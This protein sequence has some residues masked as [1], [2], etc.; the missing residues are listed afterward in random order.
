MSDK[1][2]ALNSFW[3]GFGLPAYDEHTVPDGA[4]TPYITYEASTAD[5]DEKVALTASIWYKSNSW[6]EVSQKSEEIS[7]RIGGG[8]GQP[9]DNGR[10]WIT[11]ESPFAQ[12]MEEPDDR[13][14]RRI[15]LQIA[16]EFH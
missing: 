11:K 14:I 4:V 7:Q 13:L 8:I 9:Y 16:A 3:N 12:R 15:V 6:A 2:T 1:W 10:L 5:L